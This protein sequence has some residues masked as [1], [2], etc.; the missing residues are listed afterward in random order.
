MNVGQLVELGKINKLVTSE[1]LKSSLSSAAA[2]SIQTSA[3]APP[4]QERGY[5]VCKL[6]ALIYE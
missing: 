1:G 6:A 4:T 3:A 2:R 5:P